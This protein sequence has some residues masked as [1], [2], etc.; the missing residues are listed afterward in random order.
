MPMRATPTVST[1]YSSATNDMEFIDGGN[2]NINVSSISGAF[3]QNSYMI[4]FN[5]SLSSSP[6]GNAAVFY[7]RGQNTWYAEVDAEL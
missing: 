2:T 6:S 1:N 7:Q 4:N 5:G 3:G